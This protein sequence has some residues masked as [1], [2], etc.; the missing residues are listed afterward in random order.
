[1]T[2][3]L[4]ISV[5][6]LVVGCSPPHQAKHDT[7][8]NSTPF[9]I[10]A[11]NAVRLADMRG[12]SGYCW[13]TDGHACDY[14]VVTCLSAGRM[15]PA[16]ADG[17]C[18]TVDQ[19]TSGDAAVTNGANSPAVVGANNVISTVGACRSPSGLCSTDCD[20]SKDGD[21]HD[22]PPKHHRKPKP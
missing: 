8:W 5:A 6:L 10:A 20:M 21:C 11:K 12:S 14:R 22:D 9:P 16:R 15:W 17:V 18:Y 7:G 13:S 1:M 4:L 19:P 3:A 2:R